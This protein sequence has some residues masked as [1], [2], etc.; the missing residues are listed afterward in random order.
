MGPVQHRDET[1]DDDDTAHTDYKVLPVIRHENIELGVPREWSDKVLLRRRA[2]NQGVLG[3][4]RRR[5]EA[6]LV[7][8]NIE[9]T[10]VATQERKTE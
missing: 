7:A 5:S 10:V 9:D 3:G 2:R 8:S 1:H 6:K 4:Y